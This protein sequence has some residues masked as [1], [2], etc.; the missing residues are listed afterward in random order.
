[1]MYFEEILSMDKGFSLKFGDIIKVEIDLGF[2]K[3]L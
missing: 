2:I 1:M 3:L